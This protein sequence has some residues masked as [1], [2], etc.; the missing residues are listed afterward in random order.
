MSLT[1]FVLDVCIANACSFSSGCGLHNQ[2]SVVVIELMLTIREPL[3]HLKFNGPCMHLFGV[4]KFQEIH[5]RL[6][7]VSMSYF[8]KGIFSCYQAE[9][10]M[11]ICIYLHFR[12]SPIMN[13][14]I[15]ETVRSLT[16][17]IKFD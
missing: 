5:F 16:N 1:N 11:S 8:C 6:R 2:Q 10:V 15:F 3:S 4:N 9:L 17:Y 14:Q 12:S 7:K 13:L